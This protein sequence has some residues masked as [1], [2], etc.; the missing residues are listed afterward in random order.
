MENYLKDHQKELIT[1]LD[2]LLLRVP[3]D[4]SIFTKAMRWNALT[5]LITVL[6]GCPI[7]LLTQRRVGGLEELPSESHSLTAPILGVC[8]GSRFSGGMVCSHFVLRTDLYYRKSLNY[9]IHLGYWEWDPS[10]Y[11]VVI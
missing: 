8:H 10:A 11:A 4:L 5:M 3:G 9:N 6:A 7:F 1:N 2:Q